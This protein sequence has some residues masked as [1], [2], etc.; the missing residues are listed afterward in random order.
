MKLHNGELQ[1]EDLT[2]QNAIPFIRELNEL[3][4]KLYL[5]SGTDVEDAR[6]EA[7]V[8]GYDHLF[9][10][11]IYGAVGDVTK[12]AKK[13]V[14][15][16]IL[17][18]AGLSKAGM[19]VT[20]GDGPVEIRET[21]KRGGISVGIASDEQKRSGLNQTKRTRL[22]KAGADI[23]IPDFSESEALLKILNIR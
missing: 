6:H 17:D 3:G 13:I 22:I 7:S 1:I 4:I 18:E 5:T 9:E 10:G 23:I 21:H 20:F 12:E 8:L 19:I 15:N 16:S 14:I 2:I 11:G